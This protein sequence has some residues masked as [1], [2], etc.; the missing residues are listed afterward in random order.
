GLPLYYELQQQRSFDMAQ[1]SN[2]DI[3]VVTE[4]LREAFAD[5]LLPF[6]LSCQIDDYPGLFTSAT[7]KAQCPPGVKCTVPDPVTDGTERIISFSK[8]IGRL[9]IVESN[10][11]QRM[12]KRIS[13]AKHSASRCVRSSKT[14]YSYI[15]PQPYFWGTAFVIAQG[16]IATSCHQLESFIKKDG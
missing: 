16:V 15:Q 4:N 2:V 12:A 8:S 10:Y 13:K 6:P 11:S 3:K 14:E 7:G 5:H 1:I 9:A